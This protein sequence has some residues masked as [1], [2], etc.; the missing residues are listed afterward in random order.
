M[1]IILTCWNEGPREPNRLGA[2]ASRTAAGDTHVALENRNPGREAAEANIDGGRDD[3]RPR[4]GRTKEAPTAGE[5]SE[6]PGRLSRPS[7]PRKRDGHSLVQSRLFNNEA[8]AK[9][10]HR[11]I[12]A[13]V[14]N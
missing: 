2:A 12:F 1:H 3:N 6:L 14:G 13:M 4:R 7:R 10:P 5:R 8:T 9:S 11:D